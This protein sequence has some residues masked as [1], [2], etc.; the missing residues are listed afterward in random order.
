MPGLTIRIRDDRSD[1]DRTAPASPDVAAELTD[2]DPHSGA[3]P[4]EAEFRFDG[5]ISEFCAH[6]APGSRSPTCCG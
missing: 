4:R 3:E 1:A 6:L 5:G 2:H